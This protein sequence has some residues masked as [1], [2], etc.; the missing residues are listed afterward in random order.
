MIRRVYIEVEDNPNC[1]G[2]DPMRYRELGPPDV[3]TRL[4]LFDRRDEGEWCLVTGVRNNPGEPWEPARVR[5]VEDSGVGVAYLVYG[6]AWGIRLCPV[7]RAQPWSFA[8]HDQWG[9]A[10][11]LLTDPQDVVASETTAP[12]SAASSRRGSEGNREPPSAP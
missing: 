1:A 11:L 8:D 6:G 3:V 12:P 4:R 7:E 9:E 5:K 10:Y 2:R